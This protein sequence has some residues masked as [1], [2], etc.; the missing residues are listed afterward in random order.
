MP[1][2]SWFKRD[3]IS[4]TTEFERDAV[5]HVQLVLR[6]MEITGKMDEETV[7]RLRGVQMLFGL[8]V[9]G[10]LDLATAEQIERITVQ[11]AI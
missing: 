5:R 6:C 9:T 10:A 1:S 8:P 11:H 4:P 2:P 7:S 3:I